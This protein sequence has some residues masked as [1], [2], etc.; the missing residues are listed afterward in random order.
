M[1]NVRKHAI[2]VRSQDEKVEKINPLRDALTHLKE[3]D[4]EYFTT[5]ELSRLD[6]IIN[7]LDKF[8]DE[9]YTRMST[10]LEKASISEEEREKKKALAEKLK[11][12]SPEQIDKLLKEA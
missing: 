8:I 5:L 6:T 10:D 4:T 2:K 9:A 12:L 11:H 7:K 1:G 3:V